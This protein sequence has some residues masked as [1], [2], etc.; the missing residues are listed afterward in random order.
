MEFDLDNDDEENLDK[1]I[2]IGE[3]ISPPLAPGVKFNIGR[4]IIHL[5]NLKRVFGRLSGDDPKM[6]SLNFINI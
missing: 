4:I 3:I 1:A 2:A 5:L 6:H